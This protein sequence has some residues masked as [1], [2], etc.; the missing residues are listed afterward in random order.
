MS[1]FNDYDSFAAAYSVMSDT[2]IHNAYYERPAILALAAA[3]CTYLIAFKRQQTLQQRPLPAH[4]TA[5]RQVF[6]VGVA[7][8]LLIVVLV[9][10]STA[11]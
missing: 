3:L 6:I 2:E 8:L 4:I 1:R 7:T 5:R 10:F 9:R 11:D